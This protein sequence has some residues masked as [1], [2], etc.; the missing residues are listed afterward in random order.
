MSVVF[1]TTVEEKLILLVDE[2]PCLFAKKDP[3]FKNNNLKEKKWEKIATNFEN[4]TFTAESLKK[5]WQKLRSQ[6]SGFLR[7]LK[8]PSGKG[9]GNRPFFR[10]EKS[11]RFLKDEIEPEETTFSNVDDDVTAGDGV[12]TTSSEVVEIEELLDVEGRQTTTIVPRYQELSTSRSHT[13]FG[14]KRKVDQFDKELLAILKTEEDEFELY[15]KSLAPKL[16]I[17]SEK[18]RKLFLELQHDINNLIHNAEM[19]CLE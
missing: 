4:D 2:E 14:M 11:M 19:K 5:H 6:F 15:A 7:R 3:Q 10:H 18:G 1:T 12:Q 9:A 17:I 16:R 8:N 13:K